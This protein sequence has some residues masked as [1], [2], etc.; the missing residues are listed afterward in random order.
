MKKL[1]VVLFL[2]LFAFTAHPNE[3]PDSDNAYTDEEKSWVQNAMESLEESIG[4]IVRA[5]YDTDENGVVDQAAT[6]TNQGD[7]A[8]M[9]APPADDGIFYGII[10]KLFE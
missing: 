3:I 2:F 5:V 7:L 1:Y 9:D 4:D 10:S 6:I 8:T